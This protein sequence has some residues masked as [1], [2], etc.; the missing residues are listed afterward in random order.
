MRFI[1]RTA[2]ILLLTVMCISA[3]GRTA[4]SFSE[5]Y[6]LLGVRTENS[7]G[8]LAVLTRYGAEKGEER[9]IARIPG[10]GAAVTALSAP[11]GFLVALVVLCALLIAGR[12]KKAPEN[13][14][15]AVSPVRDI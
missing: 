2:A 9:E 7:E 15:S 13:T 14:V 8:D 10:A 1:A 4:A 5:A 6:D 11:A 3:L 12:K